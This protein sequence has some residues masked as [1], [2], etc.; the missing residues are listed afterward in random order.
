MQKESQQTINALRNM[1]RKDERLDQKR[2]MRIREAVE[3]YHI[4]KTKITQLARESGALIQIDR[5]YL[6][7][8]AQFEKFIRTFQI[9]GAIRE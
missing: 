5:T 1:T 3:E 8:V 7:D 2:F 9:P 4:S 6:I